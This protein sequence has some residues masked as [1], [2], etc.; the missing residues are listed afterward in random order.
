MTDLLT[1]LREKYATPKDVLRALALDENIL[2]E[3]KDKDMSDAPLGGILE[4]IRGKPDL[5]QDADIKDL[6]DLIDALKAANMPSGAEELGEED[7]DEDPNEDGDEDMEDNG[8]LPIPGGKK[9]EDE[10]MDGMGGVDNEGGEEGGNVHM[11]VAKMLM[12]CAKLLAGAGRD[13]DEEEK[14]A[15][16]AEPRT[17]EME[18]EKK[19][20][21]KPAMD[22]ATVRKLVNAAVITERTRVV[23]TRGARFRSAPSRPNRCRMR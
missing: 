20:D 3:P 9:A 18:R 19:E 4:R 16:D 12:Q 10:D 23:Q 14:P 8:G 1:A 6:I 13:E 21:G 2:R 11:R 7:D 15:I 5:A 17:E 22:A